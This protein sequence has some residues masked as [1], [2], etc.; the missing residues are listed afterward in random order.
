MLFFHAAATETPAP[1]FGLRVLVSRFLAYLSADGLNYALGFLI[2]AWLVRVLATDQYGQLAVSTSIYQCF[3]M[4]AALG[5]DLTGP[6]LITDTGGDPIQFAAHAQSVRMKVVAFFCIPL[7]SVL[8]LLAWQR[9]HTT[10]ALLILAS[11]S[12]VVAR[13]F[14][15]TYLAVALRTPVP[16]AQSRVLGLATYLTI[17]LTCTPLIRQHVWL[18]PILNAVGVTIGRLQLAHRLRR[19]SRAG[20]A[21]KPLAGSILMQGLKSSGGQLIL[22]VLQTSDVLLLAKYV[23]ADAVGQ[24]AIVSRLYLLGSAVLGALFNSFLPELVHALGNSH[25][26]SYRCRRF[27]AANLLLGT[28]GCVCFLYGATAVSDLLSHHPLPLVHTVTPVFA[29]TFLFLSVANPFLS[30]LPSLNKSTEY[31]AITSIALI[32]LLIL[33]LILIPRR[34]VLGAA[35]GQLIVTGLLALGS[36]IAV[37]YHLLMSKSSS[38]PLQPR[39]LES[40]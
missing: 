25:E 34:G 16:L 20:I 10:L 38:D 17:L 27:F 24:Y 23:S 11:V 39:L 1:T 29:I 6:K 35:Y 31:L 22:L 9:G 4:V 26:L 18:I 2:Y 36:S 7:Q 3:M 15:L 30:L 5:L 21:K 28:L 32:T 12:M 19:H 33:D 14:D 13:A 8:A 40:E 37:G